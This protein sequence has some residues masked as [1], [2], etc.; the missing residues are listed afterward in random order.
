MARYMISIDPSITDCSPAPDW[1]IYSCGRFNATASAVKVFSGVNTTLTSYG[2]LNQTSGLDRVGVVYEFANVARLSSRVGVS[3]ISS[4][5]ACSYIDSE[6]PKS[7]SLSTL[8]AQTKAAWNSNILS[9]ITTTESDPST[10]QLLYS[11]IYGAF[12]LPSNRTG[13]NPLWN[14]TEPYYDVRRATF[15]LENL[16]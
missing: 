2:Q 3:W 13:E 14:S 10:L 7:G 1:T 4:A 16:N 15:A 6:L 5:K 9:K 12:L 8:T 11:S